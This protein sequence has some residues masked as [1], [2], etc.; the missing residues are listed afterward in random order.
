MNGGILFLIGVGG[1]MT[2]WLVLSTLSN[3]EMEN[4]CEDP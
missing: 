3:L 2:L 4:W 1:S